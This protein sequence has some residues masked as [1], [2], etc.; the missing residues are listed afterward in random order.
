[1]MLEIKYKAITNVRGPLIFAKGVPNVHIGE[2]VKI[3]FG[4]EERVGQIT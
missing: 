2:V 3:R 1:M 4:A